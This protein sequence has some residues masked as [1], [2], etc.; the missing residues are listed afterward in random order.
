MSTKQLE[1][2]YT[3]FYAPAKLAAPLRRDAADALAKMK[4]YVPDPPNERQADAIAHSF[5]DRLSMLWGPPG[6][7]KTATLGILALS[8]LEDAIA[9][10]AGLRICIGA[11]NYNAIDNV[12]RTCA[13]LLKTR[14]SAHGAM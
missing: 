2:A 6:T 12:L 14:R 1:P 13:E 11:S 4:A 9:R 8:W 3:F 7:G 10:G 5:S